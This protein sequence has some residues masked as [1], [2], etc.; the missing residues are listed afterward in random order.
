MKNKHHNIELRI[1]VFTNLDPIAYPNT[2]TRTGLETDLARLIDFE[3]MLPSLR[4]HYEP[5]H[6]T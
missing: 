2:L 6:R 5:Q 4:E 1:F 3:K